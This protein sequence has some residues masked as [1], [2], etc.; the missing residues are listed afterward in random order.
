VPQYLDPDVSYFTYDQGILANTYENLIWYNNSCS[1]CAIPWL[2]MNYTASANLA[3]YNF[4]LRPNITFA[5]GEP[6]NSTAIYFSLNRILIDDAS[7][8]VSL[9]TQAAW[10]IQNL[11]NH[12]LSYVWGGPHNYTSSWVSQVLAQNFVQVTGP[13]TFTMHIEN[14]NAAFP[15]LIAG[16]WAEILA[17]Q[18]VMQHDLALWTQSSNDY[19]L[20]YPSPS[21]NETNQVNEYFDDWAATCQS[22][23]TPHGCAWTYLDTGDNGSLA[24]TGPYTIQ[25]FNPSTNVIILSANPNY[26][27]GP[28]STK[29]QPAFTTV[30]Y[31]YVPDVSTRELDLQNAANAGQAMI[32]DLP[33]TNLYDIASRTDWLSNGTLTS[34]TN[35]V[36]VDGPFTEWGLNFVDFPMNVTNLFTGI[37]DKFQPFADL[38]MRL[39][40]SDTVNM[41]QINADV[42]NNLGQVAENVNP[43]GFPPA[44]SY[45]TSISPAY[46][47]N[48]T[49]AQNLLLQAMENPITS[50]SFENGTA[51]PAGFFNNTFGCSA[52]ALSANG[53]TCASPV[54]QTL[55][56]TYGIGDAVGQAVLTQIATAINNISTSYNM[57]LTLSVVPLPFGQLI[58]EFES[59]TVSIYASEIFSDY[60]WATNNLGWMYPASGGESGPGGWNITTLNNLNAQ[61][62]LATAQNNVS[63]VVAA[64]DAMNEYANQ[65]DMYL[66]EVWPAA[67]TVLTSN[68]GGYYYNDGLYGNTMFSTLYP[69]S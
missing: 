14:P 16:T 27:G 11:E 36:S 20:P 64:S 47:Y 32:I 48:L 42:N 28:L 17:P 26:W 39:A 54:P 45:N 18:Y 19:T 1:S 69:V 52:A 57:G 43:P 12:S 38:R 10:D 33:S 62:N 35:G 67:V 22:G 21:G 59:G 34:V 46:S 15:Y 29:I 8:P 44:G 55:Q 63:G 2:A 53:G 37:L 13:L 60:G 4:T 3:T 51:A 58:T 30:K 6:L 50:F 7:S 9:G 56:L 5:D 40:F 49:N 68:I 41:S 31:V 23:A 65:A 66:W 25:S 61:A 24:G